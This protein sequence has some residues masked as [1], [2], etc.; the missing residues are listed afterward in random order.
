MTNPPTSRLLAEDL[1]VGKTLDLGS[2]SVSAEEIIR[3]A[4]EWDNQ[5]FHTDPGA[6]RDS[7]FGE[8]IASGLHTLSIFQRLSVAAIFGRYD[9]IAGKEIRQLRFLRPVRAGDDL[10]GTLHIDPVGPDSRGR[11]LVSMTGTLHNQ[12]GRAVLDVHMD[13]LVATAKA[14]FR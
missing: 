10:T 6:A 2:H 4:S 11:A 7:Y 8:L 5:Y 1:P 12:D 9:V 3:F 13:S 14:T